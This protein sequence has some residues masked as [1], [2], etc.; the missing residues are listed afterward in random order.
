MTNASEMF[1]LVAFTLL[2]TYTIVE[3]RPIG[4]KVGTGLLVMIVAFV[5]QLFSSLGTHPVLASVVNPIFLDASFNAHVTMAVFGYAALTLST[6]YG[7][8]YLLLYRA[9]KYN[10][11]GAVFNHLPSLARLERYGIRSLAVGFVFLTL[12]I[13]FG[14]VLIKKSFSSA[15]A[16]LYLHDPK[17]VSTALIWLVFGVTL[18]VRTLWHLE[19]RKIVVIW[20]SGYVL[21]L[22]SS[23]IVNAFGTEYHN[24]L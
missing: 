22:I 15:D 6:I 13:I 11:F 7:S 18:L 12:S 4:T 5:F 9:M 17:T 10:R 20:M 24:F 16:S 21:T 1:S 14:I 3:L 19:G 23:T 2:V 8:L